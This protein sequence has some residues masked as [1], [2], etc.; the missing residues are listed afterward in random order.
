VTLYCDKEDFAL[1]GAE[2]M[3]REHTIGRRA[4]E[5]FMEASRDFE[6]VDVVDCSNMDANVHGV[7]HSYFDL[8]MAVVGDLQQLISH[9]TRASGRNGLV[10]I[11]MDRRLNVFTFLAPPLFVTNS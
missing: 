11:A 3:S 5:I 2:L 6:G 4:T 1:F 10:R 9:S 8:N 7:R